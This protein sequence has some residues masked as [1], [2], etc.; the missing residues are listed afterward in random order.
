MHLPLAAS[1]VIFCVHTATTTR[2]SYTHV[3][4]PYTDLQTF[5]QA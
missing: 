1:D 3:S 4:V 5:V 2:H